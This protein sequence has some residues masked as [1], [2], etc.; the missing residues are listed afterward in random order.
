[1]ANYRP[2]VRVASYAELEAVAAGPRQLSGFLPLTGL[3]LFGLVGVFAGLTV[4]IGLLVDW[5]WR[6]L[7]LLVYG[8]GAA[9]VGE[10]FWLAMF[11]G[12]RLLKLAA[13]RMDTR[14]K[15]GLSPADVP[16]EEEPFD[17]RGLWSYLLLPR[18][19]DLIKAA[20]FPVCFLLGVLASGQ[21][22]ASERLIPAIVV[23][24][25]LELLIY[26]A[27]YQWNDIRGW[28]E[29]RGSVLRRQ[30]GRL[31]RGSRS[32]RSALMGSIAFICLRMYLVVVLAAVVELD[33]SGPLL[34]AS[35]A[36]WGLA[37]IYEGCRSF[38]D[39]F[40]DR[41]PWWFTTA[42]VVAVGV[43]YAIRG[44]LGFVMAFR[45]LEQPGTAVF[46]L[47]AFLW[48]Y[49]IVFVTIT[50]VLEGASYC[51]TNVWATPGNGGRGSDYYLGLRRK[52]HIKAMLLA[53]GVSL[54]EELGPA[55][56]NNS[57]GARSEVLD[58]RGR[59]LTPWNFA[60]ML[61]ALLCGPLF[62][63]MV[64]VSSSIVVPQAALT[65]LVS[66]PA[67]GAAMLLLT[68][69]AWRWT[70]V[71]TGALAIVLTYGRIVD[72]PSLQVVEFGVFPWLLA[73][74]TYSSFRGSSYYKLKNGFGDGV[75]KLLGLAGGLG[76]MV[77]GQYSA[78]VLITPGDADD[79][80]AHRGHPD[81]SASFAWASL[82]HESRS[83]R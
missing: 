51:S 21:Q 52:S 46:V 53:A 58:A 17:E 5:P 16:H 63:A 3:A 12:R 24:L 7:M 73:S 55:D 70:A 39:H 68:E 34:W 42:I 40:P 76:G 13:E 38:S 75:E 29:D 80:V 69:G 10:Q 66:V 82:Q 37:V 35:A 61:C 81:S 43:G 30:R 60:M 9:A 28:E 62:V 14:L 19:E 44:C 18:P 50:W 4:Y 45:G 8:V 26:Q 15:L 74:A 31:P 27:R 33:V 47:A 65:I 32:Q 1:M 77:L 48:S 83:E 36:V 6:L 22:W 25:A 79:D 71:I 78:G 72:V 11:N 41:V 67:L 59:I 20:F 57:Q 54:R 23:W 56:N 2:P 49:G 64:S